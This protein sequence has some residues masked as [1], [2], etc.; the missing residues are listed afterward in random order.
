[1]QPNGGNAVPMKVVTGIEPKGNVAIPV[2]RYTSY[3]TDGR[4]VLGQAAIPIVAITDSQLT[5]NG[6][7]YLV[8]GLPYAVPALIVT[9]DVGVQG[10][11]PIAVYFVN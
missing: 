10:T 5:Q 3:P 8:Q 2:Y 7:R 11:E 9:S 1:M 4:Q 6:G